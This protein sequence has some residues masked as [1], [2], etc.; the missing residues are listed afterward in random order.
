MCPPLDT[1]FYSIASRLHLFVGADVALASVGVSGLA[2]LGLLVS[3]MHANASPR[4]L[5]Y[6]RNAAV[7]VAFTAALPFVGAVA[8]LGHRMLREL[9]LSGWDSSLFNSHLKRHFVCSLVMLLL[10]ALA[11]ASPGIAAALGNR[12][13][14]LAEEQQELDLRQL[15]RWAAA[16]AAPVAAQLAWLTWHV[17]WGPVGQA[18]ARLWMPPRSLGYQPSRLEPLIA[19]LILS[20][21]PAAAIAALVVPLRTATRSMRLRRPSTLSFA[22]PSR[23]FPS[24]ASPQPPNPPINLHT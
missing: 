2:A 14:R 12:R 15:H 24:Y 5:R 3:S 7:G 10:G 8:V 1:G 4:K 18:L 20:A 16:G 21:L 17:A 11:A 6:L 22:D 9:T 23:F 19:V 13:M